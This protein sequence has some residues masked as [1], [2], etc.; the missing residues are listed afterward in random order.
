MDKPEP[1]REGSGGPEEVPTPS[2]K[3]AAEGPKARIMVVDDMADI[4]DLLREYLTSEGYTVEA[5]DNATDALSRLPEFRP[6]L[7][8]LDILMPGLS[9]LAALRQI[10]ERDHEVG[11]IMVTG[12]AEDELA[13]QSLSLGAFD[14][15]TKPIDL[16]YLKW[17]VETFLLMRKLLPEERRQAT[18]GTPPPPR[19][20]S[21]TRREE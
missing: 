3:P 19:R 17:A 1:E 16:T 5:L 15:V 13:S 12:F 18:E 9:G 20:P 4:R 11:V 2:K 8:L 21:R 6:H 7:I 10:R 14:F